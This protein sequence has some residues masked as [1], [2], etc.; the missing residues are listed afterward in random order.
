MTTLHFTLIFFFIFS[1]F[2]IIDSSSTPF[3]APIEIDDSTKLYIISIFIRTPLES[4]DLLLDVGGQFSWIDCTAGSY[5]ST[6]HRYVRCRS[7]LCRS[8][9]SIACSN[10]FQSSGPGCHNDSCALFPENPVARNAVLAQA[11]VDTAA[12]MTTDGRKIGELGAVPDFV[13][14]CSDESLLKGLPEGVCGLAGLGRSNASLPAQIEK[15]RRGRKKKGFL[16]EWPTRRGPKLQ[17]GRERGMRVVFPLPAC[18]HITVTPMSGA[19]T[20]FPIK[21]SSVYASPNIF[22]LCLPNPSSPSPGS[23]FF[24]SAGPYYFSPGIDLSSHLLYT[25]LVL[26]PIGLTTIIYN[27]RP[28]AEYFIN[29]TSINVN[30][31]PVDLNRKL[32]KIDDDGIGGTRL[33]TV[34]PY[35]V[36]ESSIYKAFTKLF[37]NES[38]KLNLTVTDPV[39]P[40]DVCYPASDVMTT[41]LGPAVPTVDLV[42]HSDDVFLEDFWR[43]FDGEGGEG[44]RRSVVP[45]VC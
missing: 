11:L 3:V 18:Y 39:D 10:C 20:P 25:P 40:F 6:T 14:S 36:L 43:E 15:E 32:L 4:A 41:R 7:D 44:R 34:T 42:M 8:I 1:K 21:V 27:H 38:E 30:G 45:R 16:T 22:A 29:V 2:T 12:L 17:P 19:P 31:I 24:N 5:A 13:V 33:S 26:S 35:T 28:S 23:A 37:K 9:D